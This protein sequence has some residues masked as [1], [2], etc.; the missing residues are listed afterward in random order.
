MGFDL[1]KARGSGLQGMADRL[2]A[3]GGP[4]EIDTMPSRGTVVKGSVPVPGERR[5]R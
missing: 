4:L 2:E 1:A 5:S 3:V